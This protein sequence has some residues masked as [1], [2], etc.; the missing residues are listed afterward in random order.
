MEFSRVE[1]RCRDLP[2]AKEFYEMVF[3]WTFE[4]TGGEGGYSFIRSAD[5][6]NIG[7][8]YSSPKASSDQTESVWTPFL[9]IA[10]CHEVLGLVSASG[11]RALTPVFDLFGRGLTASVCDSTGAFFYLWQPNLDSHPSSSKK[12][13]HRQGDHAVSHKIEYNGQP[14]WFELASSDSIQAQSF[15]QK[16]VNWKVKHEPLGEGHYTTFLASEDLSHGVAA[17]IEIEA[18]RRGVIPSHWLTY[19]YADNLELAVERIN[20]AK[21]RL[22]VEDAVLPN[23]GRYCVA[24]DSQGALFA[25][26][27][28]DRNSS[29]ES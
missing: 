14:V 16:L 21:G 29:G 5:G 1:L 10:N 25:M 3:K 28:N 15:Y 20:R 23:V 11:G 19:F 27:S 17:V 6:T 22:L 26:L 9:Q 12:S 13:T 2:T 8:I 7:G 18:G 24:Q 4:E